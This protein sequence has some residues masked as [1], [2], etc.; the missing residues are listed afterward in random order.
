MSTLVLTPLDEDAGIPALRDRY[1]AL[2]ALGQKEVAGE[3]PA[4]ST[5]PAPIPAGAPI[6]AETIPGGWYTT[7]VVKR[8]EA[9][10]IETTAG[11]SAVSL[12]IWNA[13][14]TSER[15]NVADTVK[16]QWSADIRNGRVLLSDMGRVLAAL[17][18][19]SCG[20]HDALVGGSTPASVA[21][22]F[23][24][25]SV[26]NTRDNLVLAAG[27]HG[28]ARKDVPPVFT[29]FAPVRVD[30]AGR[31]GW[32]PGK[33]KAG[34]FVTLKAEMNLLV[35]LS[36]TAHPLDPDAVA[37]PG[38]VIATRFRSAEPATIA[39][40]LSPE[41]VRAYENTDPLFVA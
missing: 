20:A 19:D 33:V 8:G 40:T 7:T 34:D 26:R 25:V 27:K 39:R 6:H 5:I 38:A 15:L 23:P 29:L 35:A 32:V 21:K 30:A 1:E 36:N 12:A 31:F 24:G 28:L 9:L 37:K 11:T 10:R 2:K 16:V 22:R 14:D 18:E 17:V 41:A 13:D 4:L 3:L